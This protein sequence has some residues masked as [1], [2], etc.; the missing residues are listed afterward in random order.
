MGN[1]QVK[2]TF[3]YEENQNIREAEIEETKKK[4]FLVE[5]EILDKLP[6]YLD[7]L[8]QQVKNGNYIEIHWP[9]FD[10]GITLML[11]KLREKFL[12]SVLDQRNSKVYGNLMVE[13]YNCID[14][15]ELKKL[16]T[17]SAWKRSSSSVFK[18]NQ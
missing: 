9:I 17:W 12:I 7:F 11:S 3:D 13:G 6:K 10:Y 1:L 8:E 16:G 15:N 2:I 4:I 14:I 18:P 5:K